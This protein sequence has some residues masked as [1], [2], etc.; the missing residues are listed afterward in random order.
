MIM[1][2][3]LPETFSA[4][5]ASKE[6]LPKIH[7]LAEKRSL[8]YHG[9]PGFSL[10]RLRNEYA[11]PGF[12]VSTSVLLVENQ[13][14]EVVAVV[15]VREMFNPPVHPQIWL[16]VDPDLE[17]QGLEDYLLD[18]AEQRSLQVLDRVDPDLRV[19]MRSQA[20]QAIVSSKNAML[21]AGMEEIRH[22]FHMRRELDQ[23]PPKPVWPDGVQLRTY[24][25]DKDAF[26]VYQ[27]DEEVFLDHFGFVKEPP[28]EGFQK[29]MHHFSADD[30]YDP[31][32]WFLA[33]AGDE[34]VG[35]CL[36]RGYGPEERDAGFI[37]SLG[38]KRPW[39]RQGIAL[40]L[41]QHAFGE[42]Y[43]RG[44]YKVDLGV[45]AESL[46]GATE[47]YLKAGMFVLRQYDMYEKEL[48]PGRE[49]SV[50]SLEKP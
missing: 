41:L 14:A 43:R 21:A 10:A 29:F 20:D 22:S 5:M 42:Y 50:T 39:R 4:R 15:E 7:Q 49:I 33:A 18:W 24:H 26:A 16:F 19:A 1:N 48:R 46:T 34:I 23:A 9:I 25:P 6:D 11:F 13:G 47:L 38:V 2:K 32:L 3:E 31:S 28:E 17:N 12:E 36:C 37:S 30:S 44:I 45:D 40:A 35:I 8:H 27:V